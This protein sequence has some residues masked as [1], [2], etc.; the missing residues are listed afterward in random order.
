MLLKIYG[1]VPGSGKTL[2]MLD[3]IRATKGRYVIA[4]PRTELHDEFAA[5]L[6]DF[7]ADRPIS[8]EVLSIHSAQSGAR[9][10]VARRIENALADHAASTHCVVFI[11][12]EALFLVDPCKLAGWHVRIDEVPDGAVVA[13]AFS[14]AAS[15]RVLDALYVLEPIGHDRWFR[16]V[17]RQGVDQVKPHEFRTDAAGPLAPF[18]K[19][20]TNPRREVFVDLSAW[21]DAR[22]HGRRVHWWSIWT[23]MSLHSCASV[24]ITGAGFFQSLL[25][26]ACVFVHGDALAFER[27]DQS[28][29]ARRERPRVSIHYFTRHPGSTTWWETHDG[30]RCLVRISEYLQRIGFAGYWSSNTNIKPYFWHRFGGDAVEPRQAGTNA[31]RHHTAC[32]YIYSNK[33]QPGEH[34]L[35]ELLGLN[36]EAVT[37]AREQEDIIQFVMRGSIRDPGFDGSY[38]IYL[39]DQDQAQ[40]LRDYLINEGITDQVGVLAVEEAGVMD[41]ERPRSRNE[42]SAMTAAGTIVSAREREERRKEADRLRKQSHRKETKANRVADG[43]YRGRGRP[44]KIKT[45]APPVV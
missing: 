35:L 6:T 4:T 37:V 17:P 31:L 39:Y 3:E 5:R 43:S 18:H 11:S 25:H 22:A 38:D 29:S 34:G 26:R 13:D 41:V 33:A 36:E 7:R 2:S 16:V 45:E 9:G 10:S 20:A 28:M 44:K 12:H 32:A 15:F 1:G 19:H 23:P 21:E 30:S 8:P 24:G 27:I 40:K 14:A 42:R